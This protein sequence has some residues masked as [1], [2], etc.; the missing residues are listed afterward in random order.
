MS[1]IPHP[2]SAT[3]PLRTV[4][5]RLWMPLLLIGAAVLGFSVMLLVQYQQFQRELKLFAEQTAHN[6]LLHAQRDLE[7][8]LR[9]NE[10]GGLDSV[11]TEFGLNTNVSYAI[12]ADE[13]NRVLA[14]TQFA[15]RKQSLHQ[16]A[17]GFPQALTTQ[18]RQQRRE[19]L[20]L[21]KSAQ[22]LWAVAPITMGLQQGELRTQRQGLLVV[23]YDLRPRLEHVWSLVRQ[24]T[25]A[26]TLILLLATL[27]MTLLG[28]WLIVRPVRT[29]QQRMQHISAGDFSQPLLWQGKGEFRDLG[30][31]LER[32]G[33]QLRQDRLVLQE[34]QARYQQLA[35]AAFE[36]IIIHDGTHILDANAA[37]D[38]LFA[39]DSGSLVGR[40]AFSIIAK[41]DQP[42]VK[43]YV[44][45]KLEGTWLIDL[46]DTHGKVI[47]CEL[48]VRQRITSNGQVLRMAAMRDLREQLAAE[49]QI[50]QLSQFDPLTGLC[51]RQLLA[52]RVQ[53][54]IDLV[55][56]QPGRRAAL[57]TVGLNSFK[58]INDSLGMG[59][60]DQVLR[61][62]AQRLAGAQAQT[63]RQGQT[64]ARTHGDTFAL[65]LPDIAGPLDVASEHASDCAQKLLEHIAQPLHLNGHELHLSACA[66]IVMIPNDSQDAPELLREAETAMHQAKT[67]GQA[68]IQFFAHA[69]QEA[70]SARLSLR[71][72]L[73]YA[74][75]HLPGG[76]LLHY[77][78]QLN[79][80]GKL[81]GL[82]ALVRWQH[83]ERGFMPPNAFIAEAEA[84]GL[85][86]ALGQW[87][88]L[89]ATSCLQRWRN[90]PAC[91][92]WAHSVCM[93]VN[94]SP[95]Q[96]REPDFV[97][98]VQQVLEHT[99]LPPSQ[100]ELELTESVVMDNLQSTLDKM[101]QIRALGLRFA[102]DDFGT[103]YSSLAYLK[104]LPI[105]TLKIDRSFI[106]E[107]DAVQPEGDKRRPAVLIDAITA[108]AH[109]LELQVVAEG[110]ETPAQHERLLQVQCDKFQGYL[111][112]RPLA[113]D[114]LLA[115][116]VEHYQSLNS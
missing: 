27:G 31:A 9:R 94:V 99:G 70:V 103:G 22:H 93:S 24:R 5:L 52:Q 95:R 81:V 28:R 107:I 112:S 58:T 63:Q 43:K 98:Q 69:L 62:V 49:K 108:M 59:V 50:R 83:P 113:E 106:I 101:A 109:Q 39:P 3:R 102:L 60:G 23:A 45:Q 116:A 4:R 46:V 12:L 21:D 57:I 26:F 13:R 17:T 61:T 41:H 105:D 29:L 11:L 56:T 8:L 20:E 89:E 84:S 10:A 18:A 47:P 91:A 35:N 77:Q 79:A 6:E 53:Q 19:V 2:A 33:E 30:E 36:A 15:W 48:K 80:A 32:M 100:L 25:I 110:V 1:T 72:E 97:N 14:A 51:N 54:E 78:P 111:F 65:L 73:R 85:I 44:S 87:V 115:W 92:A 67:D 71:N 76:L 64:L 40:A 90:D 42:T 114:A 55:H 37:A 7:G 88:M 86:V 38:R 68:N 82:E 74:L 34:S 75:T 16:V 66:G 104:Q 96:F